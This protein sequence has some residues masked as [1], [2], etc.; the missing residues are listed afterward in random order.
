MQSA[1]VV[2]IGGGVIGTASAYFLA[3]NGKSVVLVEAED[4]AAGA[5]GAAS[6]VVSLLTKDPGDYLRL[7]R[8][9]V[10]L[11]PQLIDEL[12]T[13]FEWHRTGATV[14]A[15]D[16]EQMQHLEGMADAYRAC[17]VPVEM[18]DEAGLRALEPSIGPGFHGAI[19]YPNDHALDP[20]RLT[21]AYARGARRLG[22]RCLLHTRATD[23]TVRKGKVRSVVTTAGEVATE[24]VVIACGLN[25]PEMSRLVGA[26]VRVIPRRGQ[27]LITEMTPHRINTALFSAG[28]VLAK[29]LYGSGPGP[30]VRGV[31]VKE[32]FH[33]R[34]LIGTT[35]EFVGYDKRVAGELAQ[36]LALRTRR[37]FPFMGN[38]SLMRTWAGLRPHPEAGRPTVGLSPSVEGCI[39][40]VGHSGDGLA[41]S[42][43]TGKYTNALVDGNADRF[44][45]ASRVFLKPGPAQ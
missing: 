37:A 26:D 6:G 44:E 23:I 3:K 38:L 19:H 29:H 27:V 18:L 35:Y 25:T 10:A 1:D 24:R 9:S 33:N 20:F 28:M 31:S 4:L 36:A 43:I 34:I 15:D 5:T 22:A 13:D 17:G 21:Q 32:T 45:L 12:G 7:A 30:V 8:E 41:M 16:E 42:A 11:F 40:S 2:V 14:F 39:I